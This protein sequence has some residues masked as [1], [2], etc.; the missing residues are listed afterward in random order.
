MAKLSGG[1][2]WALLLAPEPPY[3]MAGGGAVRT[4]S[5]FCFLASRYRLHLVTFKVDGGPDSLNGFPRDA[6]ERVD[7][8]RLRAH[9]KDV[10]ARAFRNASRLLRGMLPLSDRLCGQESRKQVAQAISGRR[11]EVAVVEHFWCAPYEQ[12]L[13][14]RA[15]HVIMDMHNIESALHRHCAA[16]ETW[17][18]R[19][20]HSA[21]ARMAAEQERRWLPKFDLVLASSQ[22]DQERIT[23][24]APGARVAV[25]PN[26]I[27]LRFPDEAQEDHCIAFSSNLEYH[28]NVSAVRHFARR[29]WPALRRRDDQLRW[30]LIGKNPWAVKRWIAGDPRIETT[31]PVEDPLA[32]LAR[33]RVVVVPLLAAS[34]TRFKILEAWAAGRAVVSTR[35]GAEGLPAVDGE[36][37]LLADSPREM[38]DGLEALLGNPDLRKRL[39]EAGRRVV[40]QQLCWPAAWG[41]L[42]Q[43]F[44]ALTV[45]SGSIGDSF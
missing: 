33:V 12:L 23:R 31:G 42:E 4:A 29:V 10:A 3:P 13:R 9:Q 44:R 20:A 7:W 14:A 37:L 25:Y 2:D 36:N 34:G 19:W 26:A 21:F 28:P 40:E 30:R 38:L 32:E 6:A 39:G 27:P 8:V 18:A 5:I 17:P 1:S 22:A 45:K 16:T 11:Y 41:Q 35:I 24:L 43:A 15:K